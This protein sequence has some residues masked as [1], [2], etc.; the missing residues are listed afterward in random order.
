MIPPKPRTGKAKYS[1]GAEAPRS[2]LIPSD[3]LRKVAKVPHDDD[4]Q[5]EV[6][7]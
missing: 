3:S 6:E 7:K 4:E 1:G 2:A 5:E